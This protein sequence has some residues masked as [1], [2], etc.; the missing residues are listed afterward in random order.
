QTEVTDTL[1]YKF[2]FRQ[3]KSVL[4]L[5]YSDN[6]KQMER[7][8]DTLGKIANRTDCE[9]V[10]VNVEGSASPEG[11]TA[12]NVTLALRRA[13]EIRNHLLSKTSIDP[14]LVKAYSLGVDREKLVKLLDKSDYPHRDT[15]INLIVNSR[16]MPAKEVF[17]TLKSLDKGTHW[18]WMLQ[19]VFPEMRLASTSV[20]CYVRSKK[21]ELPETGGI[22]RVLVLRDTVFQRDTIYIAAEEAPSTPI[23]EEDTLPYRR[24]MV[25]ALRS[26]LLLPLLNAGIEVPLGNRWSVGADWYYPW[27][28]R[29]W[30]KSTEMKSC[31]ELLMGGA[32]VHY[33]LGSKHADGED[34]WQYRLS[35][36]AIGAYGYYGY[37]DIGHN[38]K[39][40]QG[41]F[42]NV[43]LDYVYSIRIG[44]KKLWRLEFTVGVG[45]IHSGA[46]KYRVYSEGGHAFRTGINKNF[47]WFGPTKVGISLVLPFYKKVRKEEV[48]L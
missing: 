10:A 1:L 45:Y 24:K 8:S 3:G 12:Q 46:R 9:I 4:D 31:F 16:H 5:L 41:E 14:E 20:V 32:D 40:H 43:G 37:Y 29:K 15:L 11:S 30:H 39:G 19:N 23:A 38:Y 48:E 27:L 25:V 47:N 33:W 35:G 18:Q 44:H 34:N 6:G 7:L 17:A 42:Y 36:H 28:W 26:N 2:S 22:E 21:A 13:K